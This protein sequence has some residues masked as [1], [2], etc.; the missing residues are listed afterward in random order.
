MTELKILWDSP[1]L[2]AA[3]G[4]PQM[5]PMV[6]DAA[7]WAGSSIEKYGKRKFQKL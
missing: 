2:T 6:M 5:E 1:L 4:E 3:A 7:I